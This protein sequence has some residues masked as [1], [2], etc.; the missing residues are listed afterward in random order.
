MPK[1]KTLLFSLQRK[2]SSLTHFLFGTMHSRN[3]G[4]Y[5]HSKLAIKYIHQAEVYF[6]E[7][8]LSDTG[9]LNMSDYFLLPDSTTLQSLYSEKH[10]SRMQKIL[11]KSCKID[12]RQ[13]ERFLPFYIQTMIGE[14]VLKADNR[15]PLDYYLW[16][17]AMKAGKKMSGVESLE[18]QIKILQ[19]I[20]VHA[21]ARS[22]KHLS[23]NTAKFRKTIN[24][25][26]KA[27]EKAD[28]F[29]LYKITSK[30]LGALRNLLLTDRNIRMTRIIIDH[31]T[32]EPSFFAVGAAHL[33]GRS[34]I[35]HL[36][37]EGGYVVK[38]VE[39]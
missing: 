5:I 2:G 18:E 7:I 30:Q 27:Y 21:Q 25:L 38:P 31:L 4:A 19:Q 12:L 28:I 35:I 34:G 22:L 15:L 17:K 23:E 32:D 13:F 6:A 10:F 1:K 36:L 33:A 39:N 3:E 16:E 11:L 37:K 9:S 20:P 29:S 24:K 14:F 8:N 26:N